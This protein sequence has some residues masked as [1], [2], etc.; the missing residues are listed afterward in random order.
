MIDLANYLESKKGEF[1]YNYKRLT[2]LIKNGLD[3]NNIVNFCSL[4]KQIL[5]TNTEIIDCKKIILP[6]E[7]LNFENIIKKNFFECIK[8]QNK[9]VIKPK[10]WSPSNFKFI[11]KN[12]D[13][14][15]QWMEL[16]TQRKNFSKKADPF[17][18][19]IFNYQNYSL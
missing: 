19:Q 3:S 15:R 2:Q 16:Q 11:D 10:P 12:T 13:I 14:L 4:L 7:F 8:L 1:P 17:I 9:L 5:L 18:H 6:H